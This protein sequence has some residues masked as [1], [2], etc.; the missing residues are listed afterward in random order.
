MN[1]DLVKD[2]EANP[3]FIALLGDR[4]FCREFWTA[5]A[6]V[7]WFKKYDPQAPDA[8]QVLDALAY[9]QDDENRQWGASFRGMGGVIADLRN[10]FHGASEDYMDWYCSN[11]NG[12]FLEYEYDLTPNNYDYGYVTPRVRAALNKMG[13]YPV[14]DK[15][16]LEAN[17]S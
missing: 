13:W 9:D 8:E 3:E 2:I 10:E 16:Y 5:F 14:I 7:T 15:Y 17:G 1:C 12:G 4:E 11:M 6:N